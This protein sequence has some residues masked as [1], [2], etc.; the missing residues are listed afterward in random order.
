MVRK[1]RPLAGSWREAQLEGEGGLP[2]VGVGMIEEV[3]DQAVALA[4]GGGPVI[5]LLLF[6]YGRRR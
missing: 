2:V 4:L 5:A 1:L 6:F 3:G